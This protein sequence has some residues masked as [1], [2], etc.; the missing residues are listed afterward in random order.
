M[1]TV[2]IDYNY[3]NPA[4]PHHINKML[5]KKWHSREVSS[6]L[7]FKNKTQLQRLVS[8]NV[9]PAGFPSHFACPVLMRTISASPLQCFLNKHKN[10]AWARAKLQMQG[11]AVP[12]SPSVVSCISFHFNRICKWQKSTI[13]SKAGFKVGLSS[14][15]CPQ[16]LN[17][18]NKTMGIRIPMC[19]KQG[20][21]FVFLFPKGKHT[22]VSWHHR[23]SMFGF[24]RHFFWFSFSLQ[25]FWAGRMGTT[26]T[27]GLH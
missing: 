14:I 11:P 13:T 2:S 18:K 3:N 6:L 22:K 12:Q 27:C 1:D 9:T 8:I 23:S 20:S 21:K 26:N 24:V 25:V 15:L 10:P 4:K 19:L 5:S 7:I 16:N 17:T